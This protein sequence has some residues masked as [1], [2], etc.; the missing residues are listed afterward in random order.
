[1]AAH[2]K[3]KS[4]HPPLTFYNNTMDLTEAIRDKIEQLRLSKK[5]RFEK[6]IVQL[7]TDVHEKNALFRAVYEK[8]EQAVAVY[9]KAAEE[10]PTDDELDR[11]EPHHDAFLS[12]EPRKK[13]DV[14]PVFERKATPEPAYEAYNRY[15]EEQENSN[16]R[17][18]DDRT[19]DVNEDTEYLPDREEYD[20]QDDRH[21]EEQYNTYDPVS[22]NVRTA[23]AVCT[24][25]PTTTGHTLYTDLAPTPKLFSATLPPLP[26]TPPTPTI[27]AQA[28]PNPYER[29][30]SD[31]EHLKR[32]ADAIAR[33]LDKTQ[34]KLAFARE[35][36]QRSLQSFD[37]LE[38]ELVS[39]SSH[40]EEGQKRA[41]ETLFEALD[42]RAKDETVS[43]LDL[44]DEYRRVQSGIAEEARKRK[45]ARDDPFVVGDEIQ[46]AIVVKEDGKL[47]EDLE[48]E[49]KRVRR[50][51]NVAWGVAATCVAA[52]ASAVGYVVNEGGIAAVLGSGI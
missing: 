41:L 6:L 51:R 37:D 12:Q 45:R 9:Q 8:F 23:R 27:P 2:Q 36:Y 34:R 14:A 19:E 46:A 43:T 16:H 4:P 33:S 25:L 15:Q 7:D 18:E 5:A 20:G 26:V 30:K 50:G 3:Q 31:C 40:F 44:Y 39:I 11:L 10:I 47:V 22:Q 29:A 24:V 13:E 1:M 35:D 48:R 52:V 32:R 21:V 42:G 49:I 38:R 28:T 17:F